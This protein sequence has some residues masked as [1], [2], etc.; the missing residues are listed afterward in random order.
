MI[1]DLTSSWRAD[2]YARGQRFFAGDTDTAWAA[3]L[4]QRY[5]LNTHNALRLDVSRERQEK[6]TW[7]TVLI[8]LHHYF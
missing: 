8:S 5:T 2:L 3:G 7:N 6:Q 4:R 1:A